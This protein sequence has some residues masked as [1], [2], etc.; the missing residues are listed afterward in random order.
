ME[1]DILRKIYFKGYYGFNNVG[2]D[3]FC[4]TADW[5]CNNL[6]NNIT[7]VFIGERLPLLSSSAKKY[8]SPS[9]VIRKLYEIWV[10]LVADNIIYFGGSLFHRI[11][12]VT[13]IKYHLNKYSFLH[14]KLGAI[15]VSVGPFRKTEDH[16]S[17]MG[18][19]S[20]LPFVAV[21]DYD[22]Y[23]LLENEIM[24]G[25][26]S[27]SFDPAIL[28]SDVYPSLRKAKS[29]NGKKKVAV[30][31]CYYERYVNGDRDCEKTRIAAV[32]NFLLRLVDEE[33]IDEI[34]F[35]EFHGGATNGD[36]GLI[37]EFDSI[38]QKQVKTRIVEYTLDTR[39]FCEEFNDCDLVIGMRLHS[40]ILAYALEIPFFLVEYHAKC[41]SFLDTIGNNY[42]FS[43]C[44]IERNIEVCRRIMMENFI[45]GIVSPEYFRM[46]MLQ[47]LRK[48]GSFICGDKV[49]D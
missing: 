20:K 40:A 35:F 13:D 46:L 30:S 9:Y 48:I 23:E 37:L 17:I 2:D 6:W 49:T 38:L 24:N 18:L 39:A 4:V 7:P 19:L 44:D 36:M 10:C 28:I 16:Q 47:E 25:Y 14:S 31:L 3:I 22:S 1:C 43:I 29:I 21:R 42:R 27:F 41:T 5:I 12:G 15:G 45:P 34:V 33:D 32:L 8:Q 26:L 11:D